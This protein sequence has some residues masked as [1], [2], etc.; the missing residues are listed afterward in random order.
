MC[1]VLYRLDDA[2]MELC[3]HGA[4]AAICDDPV[5]PDV[6]LSSD[7]GYLVRMGFHGDCNTDSID[8]LFSAHTQY[9]QRPDPYTSGSGRL[10]SAEPCYALAAVYK[11]TPSMGD[12]AYI[13]GTSYRCSYCG[14]RGCGWR[15]GGCSA[16]S[17]YFDAGK[18]SS[19]R[20]GYDICRALC[21]LLS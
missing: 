14:N 6:C 11:V 13:F 18:S 8:D 20:F 2:A 17:G 3:K 10:F 4:T 9:L 21:P 16:G 19:D 15:M 5:H 7:Y 1:S 12:A